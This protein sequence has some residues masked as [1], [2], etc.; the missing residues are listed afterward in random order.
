MSQLRNR[1]R[2]TVATVAVCF[3]AFASLVGCSTVVEGTPQS[4]LQGRVDRLY[5]QV[6]SVGSPEAKYEAYWAEVCDTEREF[7]A[8]QPP[9]AEWKG[10]ALSSHYVE[11]ALEYYWQLTDAKQMPEDAIIRDAARFMAG[12]DT[13]DFKR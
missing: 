5:H 12:R 8:T 2:K 9:D 13:C 11:A 4:M 10:D 7:E 3:A 6:E 1:S